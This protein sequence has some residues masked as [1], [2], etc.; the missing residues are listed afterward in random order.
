MF[1]AYPD[2]VLRLTFHCPDRVK[3]HGMCGERQSVA[4]KARA[5]FESQT[6]DR[7]ALRKLY[8]DYTSTDNI[9]WAH[10]VLGLRFILFHLE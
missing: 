5:E 8:S 10:W 4:L 9:E 1:W 7:V 2:W 6:I 3:F